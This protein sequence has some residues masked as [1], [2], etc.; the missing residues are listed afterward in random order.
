M[1]TT[2]STC[3]LAKQ[4]QSL[5]DAFQAGENEADNV[6]FRV[7]IKIIME[8]SL[9]TKKIVLLIRKYDLYHLIMDNVGCRT[10]LPSSFVGSPHDMVQRFQ[11]AMLLVQKFEKPDLFITMTCNPGWDEI[12]NELLPGQIVQDRPDLLTRVFKSKFEQFKHDI[13]NIEVFGTVIAYVFVFEFQKK[14]LSHGHMLFIIDENDKLR[15][16]NDYDQIVRDEMPAKE[17]QP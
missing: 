15:N 1:D 17:E 2:K 3:Y 10:I 8:Y 5:Q 7:Q 12:R 11:N 13:L 14:G 4:Y 6:K 9:S 16:P